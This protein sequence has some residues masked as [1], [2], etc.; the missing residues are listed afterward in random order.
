MPLCIIFPKH[1]IFRRNSKGSISSSS[2]SG[3]APASTS[4]AVRTCYTRLAPLS[5]RTV[6]SSTNKANTS[7]HSIHILYSALLG[8]QNGGLKFRYDT[9]TSSTQ[10]SGRPHT[11]SLWN[12]FLLRHF[13]LGLHPL[14]RISNRDGRIKADLFV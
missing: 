11:R 14:S 10:R 2:S 7:T 1:G 3:I 12:N 13:G 5:V 6:A 4:R 9:Y 8:L